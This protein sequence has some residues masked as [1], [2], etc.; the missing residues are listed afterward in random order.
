MDR[1]IPR[2]KSVLHGAAPC[3]RDRRLGRRAFG[4]W[5]GSMA[6]VLSA[7]LHSA[8]SPPLRLGSDVW[9]P[10]TDVE[11][12]PREALDLVESALLRTG[13]KAQFSIASWSDVLVRLEKGEVDGSAAMWKSSEREKQLLFSEPYLENRLVLV[14]PKGSDVSAK[15]LMDLAGRRL[16]LARGYEY[17]EAVAKPNLQLVLRDSDAECLR[18]VLAKQADY[19]LLDQLMVDHLFRF[20]TAK[21]NQLISTGSAPLVA[22][23]LHFVLRRDYP[24]AREIIAGFNRSIEKMQADGT[25]NVLLHVPWLERRNA[26]GKIEYVASSKLP[27][28]SH[29]SPGAAHG[30]YEIATAARRPAGK[31]A[32]SPTYTIDGRS[33]DNWGDAA[34][35]LERSNAGGE[36]GAYQYSTG[37]V[38]GSF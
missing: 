2:A 12:K 31:E 26:Q 18:A 14:A 32:P 29:A 10:F 16:A 36:K 17:G 5:M 15:S 35:A 24:G 22:R 34:T 3:S 4:L 27:D 33:Y 13:L 28:T 37:F 11:G 8:E 23:P 9:P 38:L 20:Y 7:Q 30:S 19:L 1:G 25:Y 6:S 21:A